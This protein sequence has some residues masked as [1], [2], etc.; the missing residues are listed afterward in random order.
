M[1]ENRPHFR[2]VENLPAP[3][4][5]YMINGA[6]TVL[7]MRK[8]FPLSRNEKEGHGEMQD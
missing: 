6:L 3:F 1:V 7:P 5:Q 4:L 2:R 8:Q